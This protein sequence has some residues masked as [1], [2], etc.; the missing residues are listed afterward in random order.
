MDFFLKLIAQAK[1][2]LLR[3]LTESLIKI[4]LN[5]NRK[6]NHKYFRLDCF[7]INILD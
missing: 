7:Y 3:K 4:G 2:K 5:K 1:F 6:Q